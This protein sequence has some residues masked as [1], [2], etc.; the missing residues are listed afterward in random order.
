MDSEHVSIK[1][2]GTRRATLAVTAATAVAVVAALIA[3]VDRSAHARH[4]EGLRAPAVSAAPVLAPLDRQAGVDA[5]LPSALSV[6]EHSTV[7]PEELP[8]TF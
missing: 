8:A 6:F 3:V 2:P 4:S 1:L 5:S 7:L